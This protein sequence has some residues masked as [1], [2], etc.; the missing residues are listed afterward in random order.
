MILLHNL[1]RCLVILCKQEKNELS[2][3]LLK[4]PYFDYN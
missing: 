4:I 1:K 3:K 2:K